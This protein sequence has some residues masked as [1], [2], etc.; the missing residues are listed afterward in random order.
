MRAPHS[1]ELSHPF[2]EPKAKDNEFGFGYVGFIPER[3]FGYVG[4]SPIQWRAK[5]HAKCMASNDFAKAEE[6]LDEIVRELKIAR[7]D[8][9]YARSVVA[10]GGAK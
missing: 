4:P 10:K 7:H 6:W 8:L 9:A 5:E 1:A 3:T 2:L